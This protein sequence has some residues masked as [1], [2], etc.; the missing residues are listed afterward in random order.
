[1]G[2]MNPTFSSADWDKTYPFPAADYDGM[3]VL[4]A[5]D[6]DYRKAQ[7]VLTEIKFPLKDGGFYT[8]HS[9]VQFPAMKS[10]NGEF[11]PDRTPTV[12]TAGDGPLPGTP[13]TNV[14]MV[15]PDFIVYEPH[16]SNNFYEP[17]KNTGTTWE[18]IGIEL[19][20]GFGETLVYGL[21]N[22][23]FPRN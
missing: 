7:N 13:Q 6:P 15:E 9:I 12:L 11:N 20:E 2:R 19:E 16:S 5:G 22:R 14:I 21:P 10:P 3:V 18:I 1:M 4:V 23:L 17:D 8:Y